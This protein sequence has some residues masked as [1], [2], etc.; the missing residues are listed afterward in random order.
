MNKLHISKLKGVTVKQIVNQQIEGVNVKQIV[1][2]QQ[3]KGKF[4]LEDEGQ[5]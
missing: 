4:V 1:K 5:V 2:P 3:I